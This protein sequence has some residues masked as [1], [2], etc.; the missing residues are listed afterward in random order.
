MTV[1]IPALNPLTSLASGDQ[2]VIR[3]V[4]EGSGEPVKR[5]TLAD[6]LAFMQ[7]QLTFPASVLSEEYHSSAQTI[8]SGGA[9]TLAHGLSA[10]P[11][12]VQPYLVC[13]TDEAGYVVG[14]ELFVGTAGNRPSSSTGAS[15][16][17]DAVNL[18]IRFGNFSSVFFAPNKTTGATAQLTNTSWNF[19]IRA[20]A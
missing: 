10:K 19:R 5:T 11:K 17:S 8:S 14:D 18:N 13:V 16:V 15:V 4:S 6:L 12:L 1:T 20:W 3:D 7:A 9:L 2:I